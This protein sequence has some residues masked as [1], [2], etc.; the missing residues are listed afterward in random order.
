MLDCGFSGSTEDVS[1]LYHSFVG[2]TLA[3][4]TGSPWSPEQEKR[5]LSTVTEHPESWPTVSW[6]LA[7]HGGQGGSSLPVNYSDHI[8]LAL[9]FSQS[10]ISS[11]FSLGNQRIVWAYVLS[12]SEGL[13][14]GMWVLK[15]PPGKSPLRMHEAVPRSPTNGTSPE[16]SQQSSCRLF[17]FTSDHEKRRCQSD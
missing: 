2:C 3:R 4:V 17:F 6:D 1:P 11:E 14:T 12:V 16:L 7:D 9:K 5:R 13:L 15:Q 10:S 8:S